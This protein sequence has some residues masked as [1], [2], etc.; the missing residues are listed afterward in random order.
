MERDQRYFRSASP[1]LCGGFVYTSAIDMRKFSI[2]TLGCKVNQYESEQMA[3]LLRSHGWVE[4]GPDAAELRIVNTC[5]VTMEAAS[6]S[7]QAVRRAVRAGDKSKVIVAGCW[8]TSDKQ[9]ASQMTGV[10]LVLTHQDNVAD[11][12]T[13]FGSNGAKGQKLGVVGTRSLPLLYQRQHQQQRAFL[14]IQDGCDAHCTYCIIPKLRP[15]LWSKP[16]DEL[17]REAN[18]LVDAG[19]V[20]LVLTGIFLGAYGRE[21]ALR[22]RQSNVARRPLADAI[23]ALCTRVPGLRRVRLSS[24]EPGDLDDELLAALCSHRQIVPHFHVP[25]QSG[26]DAILRRM[27]RQYRRDDFLRL[28]D[29]LYSAFDRPALTT[30]VI[31]GFPG[32]SEAAFQQTLDVVQRARF[33]HVHAFAFSPRPGTAAARWQS[34]RAG[35]RGPIVG[36]R[37][38]LLRRLAGAFSLDFRSTFVNQT[39]QLLV[40]RERSTPGLWRHGRCERYFDVHFENDCA[41]TGDAAT[42]DLVDVRIDRV[43][44]TRTFGTLVS[45]AAM[46]PE[47]SSP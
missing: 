4:S 1:T 40:E 17:V 30:D 7:R 8:A 22:R 27:N 28:V 11:R 6:K 10:D 25:L 36:Q 46:G 44:P 24:L 9:A 39:V 45:I 2:Q 3:S 31:V 18:Q 43:T 38:D 47:H 23:D 19:H 14:K 20:E 34:P 29:R 5:S 42:G 37:I 12:L 32:E 35:I 21:T 16:L 26:C 15:L 33:T 13:E 41:A